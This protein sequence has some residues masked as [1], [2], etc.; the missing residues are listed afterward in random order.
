M[1]K[2]KSDKKKSLGILT[3]STTKTASIPLSP[4]LEVRHPRKKRK[5]TSSPGQNKKSKTKRRISR[6]CSV[7]HPVSRPPR[8]IIIVLVIVVVVIVIIFVF[9]DRHAAV[10]HSRSRSLSLSLSILKPK[11]FSV[12][13]LRRLGASTLCIRGPSGRKARSSWRFACR[14]S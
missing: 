7:L 12:S 9:I 4:T 8:T 3:S 6:P 14:C 5:R 2:K 13:I 11:T 10:D 1:I